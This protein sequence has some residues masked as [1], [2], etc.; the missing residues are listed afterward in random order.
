[1]FLCL[2]LVFVLQCLAQIRC[3]RPNI[4]IVLADD[5]GW[6]DV[7]FHSGDMDTPNIDALAYNGVILTRH[8]SQPVCTPSRAALLTGDYPFRNGMQGRPCRAGLPDGLR[9]GVK[10]MPEYFSS[11]GYKS[12]LIGK[13]HLGYQTPN[14]LPT[15]RGFNSFFGYLNGFLGYWDGTHYDGDNVGRDIRRNEEEAWRPTYGKYLTHLLTEEAINVIDNHEGTEG[16]LM[17]VA[18]A[19]IHATNLDIGREAPYDVKNTTKRGYLRGDHLS[20]A[21]VGELDWSIGQIVLALEKKNILNNTIIVFI[22]DNGAP[23]SSPNFCNSGSNWPLRGEKLSVHEGGVR[24]IAAVWSPLFEEP[25]RLSDQLF[26]ITDWLPTL[27]A[28]AGGDP[29]DLEIHDGI[30]Q[31]PSLA[32]TQSGT[33]DTVVVDIDD[34]SNCEAIIKGNWKMVKNH[35]FSNERKF[36]DKYYGENGRWLRYNDTNLKSSI[37]AKVLGGVP[38]NYCQLR[39][40]STIFSF[41][42]DEANSMAEDCH[43]QYC[44]YDIYHDPTEC[45]NIAQHHTDIVENLKALL[46]D[47]RKHLVPNTHKNYD[48]RSDPKYWNDYWSPW[49]NETTDE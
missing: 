22:S 31:W 16:L 21:V 32:Q 12:H 5:M 46:D 47:Y 43:S 30:N 23:S 34:V 1:M 6:N 27:Y 39:N 36:S 15:R 13:W 38:S 24:T 29:K 40:A 10:L 42:P 26:H 4:V 8:Y 33:R 18:E 45:Y 20:L 17:I 3:E 25:S 28:A 11:L 2:G 41:C 19:A 48:P 9:T 44:L 37:V 14:H 49:L 35:E 7:G